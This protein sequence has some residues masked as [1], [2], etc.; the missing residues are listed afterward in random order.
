MGTKDVITK[1]LIR[2]IV[3]D[4]AIYLLDLKITHLEEAP[5][6]RQRIEV[7][8]ADIVMKAVDDTGEEFILHLE[9]QNDNDHEMALRMMRYYTDIALAYPDEVIRQYVIYIGK[10]ALSMNNRISQDDWHYNYQLIDMHT[11]DCEQFIHKDNPDVLVLAILCDFKGKDSSEV[12]EGII[13]R[14]IELTA[15]QPERLKNYLKMLET[16]ST[17]RDLSEIFQ[18]VESKMLSEIDIEKLPSYR[19]G[20]IRGEARGEANERIQMIIRAS[21]QGFDVK[22]IAKLVNLSNQEVN[23]VLQSEQKNH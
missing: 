6:E 23:K 11:L 2:E 14:L 17:N 18:E 21:S 8:H 4:M 5:T 15:N 22:T 20:E 9:L 12:V 16:L 10:A 7:R 3:M 1:S 13:R 19:I